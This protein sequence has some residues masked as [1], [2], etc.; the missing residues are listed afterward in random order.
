MKKVTKPRVSSKPKKVVAKK[1]APS[2]LL[3]ASTALEKVNADL[4][5]LRVKTAA[6]K[7]VLVAAKAKAS[8]GASKADQRAAVKA[9]NDV[10]KLM[11]KGRTLREKMN[12]LK[13][14]YS[15]VKATEALKSAEALSQ[16]TLAKY[17]AALAEK[18]TA[19][20]SKQ[21]TAYEKKLKASRAKADDVKLKARSRR[22]VTKLKVITGKLAGKISPAGV[23]KVSAAVK[24][25][26]V[27]GTKQPARGR[28]RPPK[29]AVSSPKVSSAPKVKTAV[30]AA[31]PAATKRGR[32]RPPKAAAAPVAASPA[33]SS[34]PRGRGRPPKAK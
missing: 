20:I 18:A 4:V 15:V 7:K 2:A 22:E 32:G 24:P 13:A 8:K 16:E 1:V 14:A 5:E 29:A 34:A 26:S 12:E 3:K 28:G 25:A 10:S 30:K 6:A 21:V 23:K 17:K 9:G 11:A 19:D 33:E 27:A 31:A